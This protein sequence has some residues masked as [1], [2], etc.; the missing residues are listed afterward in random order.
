MS[1]LFTWAQE[2]AIPGLNTAIPWA[3]APDWLDDL[4]QWY[5]FGITPS[6]VSPG[7]GAAP[8]I[9]LGGVRL[10]KLLLDDEELLAIGV[11]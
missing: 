2:P 7:G 5:D 1:V 8:R 11:L 10:R 9:D 4:P 6:V 3:V